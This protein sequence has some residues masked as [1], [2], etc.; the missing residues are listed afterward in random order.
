MTNQ[1]TNDSSARISEWLGTHVPDAAVAYCLELWLT[2]PFS[3][4]ITA[5]RKTKH[6]DYR[7]HPAKQTHVI[8]VNGTLN[9]YAFLITYVHEIAH[10]DAFLTHGHDIAPHGKEWKHSFQGLMRPMLTE[11]VFPVAI[12][13]ALSRHMQHP[14]ASSSTDPQ[15]MMALQAYDQTITGVTLATVPLKQTFCFHQRIFT[16][17]EVKRTRAWC[18]EV[19]SGRRYTIPIV[20]LVEE[21]GC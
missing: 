20:A 7:Y 15:L 12:L 14:K 4:K 10:L 16:K 5:K 8:T 18:T 9:R 11:E 13:S 1:P 17:D 3:L 21:L 2:Y 19:K 6:G